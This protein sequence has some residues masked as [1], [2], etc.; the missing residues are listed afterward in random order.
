MPDEESDRDPPRTEPADTALVK[1]TQNAYSPFPNF[2]H[3]QL[4]DWFTKGKSGTL[5]G[6]LLDELV[7]H[8]RHPQFKLEELDGFSHRRALNLLNSID[9]DNSALPFF[10]SDKWVQRTVS[11]SIPEGRTNLTTPLG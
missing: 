3:Y 6:P 11:I 8:L 9:N 5:S 4:M 2:S 1:N 10:T 7:K